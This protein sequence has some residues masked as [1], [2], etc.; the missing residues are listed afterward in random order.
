MK[1][2]TFLIITLVTVSM[3][4]SQEKKMFWDGFD[5]VKIDEISK[6]YPEYTYWI[7]SGYLSGIL[8]AKSYY[9][10]KAVRMKF[11]ASDKIFDDLIKTSNNRA[12]I[13]GLDMFYKDVSNRYIPIPLALI[14]TGMISTG[15]LQSEIDKF[16]Y[17]SKIWINE[18]T[19]RVNLEGSTLSE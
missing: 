4:F 3:A 2:L 19:V 18:L 15:S 5:W 12:M 13:S 16:V 14:A 6:E 7:K 17:E 10:L 8:D 9:S 11:P 1:K